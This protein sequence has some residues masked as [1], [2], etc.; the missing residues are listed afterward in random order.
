ML[1]V[2]YPTVNVQTFKVGQWSGLERCLRSTPSKNSY[3]L[4]FKTDN[5]TWR[6]G[7]I[8]ATKIHVCVCFFIYLQ[9]L[10]IAW[11]VL[12]SK[13]PNHNTHFQMQTVA[14]VRWLIR[15]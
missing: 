7:K 15:A 2:L 10:I 12:P 5:I 1:C 3:K 8:A 6:F 11:L 4:R 9:R 14:L 13:S